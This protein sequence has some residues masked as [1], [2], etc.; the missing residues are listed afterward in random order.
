MYNKPGS[1][2]IFQTIRMTMT[3][4]AMLLFFAGCRGK[5]PAIN[6]K[7]AVALHNEGVELGKQEKW[8]EAL[9]C[10]DRALEINPRYA[11]TWYN[12]GVAL[13]NLARWEETLKYFDKALEINKKY[14][15]AY[16]N[17]GILLHKQKQFEKAVAELDKIVMAAGIAEAFKAGSVAFDGQ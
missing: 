13:G 5:G 15:P 8:E 7:D 11:E 3:T 12:K 17:R 10:F 6:P 1:R 14:S 4:A 9:K 16:N 2:I